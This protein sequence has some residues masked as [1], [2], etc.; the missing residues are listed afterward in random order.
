MT[1]S[2]G[3]LKASGRRGVGNFTVSSGCRAVSLFVSL[4]RIRRR[5]CAIRGDRIA[6]TTAHV[7]GFFEGTICSSCIGRM[8]RSSRVFRFTRALT[9]CKRLGSGLV[10]MGMDVL[11]GNRCGKSVPSGTRVYKCG[12]FCEIISVGC[13]C[14]VSRRSRIPV[15]VSFG[16]RNFL[17]PYLPTSSS[18]RSCRSFVTVVPNVYLTGLCRHCN[19]ELLR[20]GIH[21]FLRFS[22][23]VGGN[24]ESAV[25]GR[26]RVFLTFGGNLT[27]ATS[28]VR[29]SRSGECVAGVSGLRVI[30]NKRAATSVCRAFGGSGTSVS[31]VF[32][33]TGISIVGQVRRCDGVMSHVSQCTG[34]RGGMGSTSF[35]TGGP[36]LITL[37]GLSHYILAPEARGSIGRA[38]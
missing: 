27:T 8:T 20:R 7:A 13:V 16:R 37:R 18:G 15:R 30:G 36:C 21:S 5:M 9:G 26:P 28:R 1:F 22:K 38:C 34:A 29:L 2:R 24:V 35:A 23:G 17:I 14:R 32:I 4:C 10:H 6:E 19:T 11:A 31:G 3:T 33:R 25:G 12:V